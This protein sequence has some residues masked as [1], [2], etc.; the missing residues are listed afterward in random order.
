[1]ISSL[2]VV[3]PAYNEASRLG[4]TLDRVA[5]FL[6]ARVGR[7]QILVVNDG[8]TDATAE[9]ARQR[10][11]Q[12]GAPQLE[13]RV[14]DNPGNRGKGY[15]VRHGMLEA[16]SD[17]ALFSDADLS[18]PIEECE[19]LLAAAEPDRADVAIG[20]RALNRSLIGVHQSLFR[21]NAGRF[22]NLLMRLATGLAIADT[23]CG[24]K[25]FRREAARQ[26]F[27]RQRLERFGF[28]VELLYLAR[29]LGF[30]I[31][32]V[33]VRWNHAEGTKVSMLADSLDMFLDLG[34]VRL[35]DWRG[36]YD[37]PR[38]PESAKTPES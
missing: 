22:F 16:T 23:Q 13:I 38:Q 36:L 18:S 30:R 27:R 10:R 8:S 11:E 17:W 1:L 29:Q 3:I 24:F 15:S 9:L 35:N 34:R 7:G 32:E 6:R 21:E 14:L 33:P 19:K 37:A 4:G 26:I 31:V 12:L 5:E 28:D 25:L 2:S 20:S